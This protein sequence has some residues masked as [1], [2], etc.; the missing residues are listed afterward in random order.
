LK[1]PT[2]KMSKSAPDVSSRIQLTDTA[3]EIQRKVRSAVTDS[4][5][6]ITYDPINRRGTSN[7]LSIL[8]ACT[9]DPV[10]QIAASYEGK[11][12]GVLKKDV[13]D[14][15]EEMLKVPRAEFERLRGEK[16]LLAS[17]AKEGAEKAK[18]RSSRT[19]KEVRNMIGL[20]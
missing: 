10:E 16:E 1:D 4:I 7:L 8:S 18:E 12:H 3:S 9:G 19:L 17:I 13:A 6:G 20:C 5:Q 2:A 15:L 14:A 11:G